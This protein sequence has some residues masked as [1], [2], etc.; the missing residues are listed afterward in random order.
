MIEAAR[1]LP[2]LREGLMRTDLAD[3][4]ERLLGDNT[5]GDDLRLLEFCHALWHD[6]SPI[7]RGRPL[8]DTDLR[9][10]ATTAERGDAQSLVWSSEVATLV[11]QLFCPCTAAGTL[12]IV[13]VTT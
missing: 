8:T 12:G 6:M 2:W 9:N 4:L 11:R 3:M 5:L 1:L 13:S 10:A 7:W